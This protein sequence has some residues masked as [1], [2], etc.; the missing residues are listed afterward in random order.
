M[1]FP[2]VLLV[3]DRETNLDVLEAVLSDLDINLLRALSGEQAIAFVLEEE[4]AVV[5]LDV[6]MPTMDGFETAR[7]I[8]ALNGRSHVP[9]IFITANS[10]PES[11][12]QGYE[13]GA[14]DFLAKPIT[15][16]WVRAKVKIFLDLYNTKKREVEMNK[17]LLSELETRNKYEIELREKTIQ[18]LKEKT[19]V[20]TIIESIPQ[21]ILVLDSDNMVSLVNESFFKILRKLSEIDEFEEY[22]KY[23]NLKIKGKLL[24]T[25][26]ELKKTNNKKNMIIE[27]IDGY[28][29]ELVKSDFK[30]SNQSTSTFG[31]LILIEIRD[32]SNIMERDNFRNQLIYTVSHEL[33]SPITAILLSANN[34]IKYF[35]R[36]NNETR[37]DLLLKLHSNSMLIAEMIDDLLLVSNIET[38]DI[39]LKMEM[40]DLYP[41]LQ[42]ISN[43]LETK[44]QTKNNKINFEVNK[45]MQL[46]GDKKRIG[47]VIRNLLDNAIKYSNQDSVINLVVKQNLVR[48]IYNIEVKGSLVEITDNGIGIKET[49]LSLIFDK[50]YRAEEVNNIVG[51]GLGLAICKEL[52]TKHYGEIYVTSELNVG[53]T[54]SFFLPN[55]IN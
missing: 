15:P 45:E 36:M 55:N 4:P 8:R 16:Q 39:S 17:L 26:I 34:L 7:K 30:L 3:D 10:N 47:Q 41:L 31:T 43:Q 20:N 18:I 54:F 21:G 6:V 49:D 51:T 27:P 40:F 52:I 33:R 38:K 13:S 9:I 19:R 1:S 28:Y 32:I 12:L 22:R 46:F 11:I 35:D 37:T 24:N 42:E 53:S 2:S 44:A 25:I 5:L 50:F 14:V 48:I 23:P 29:L